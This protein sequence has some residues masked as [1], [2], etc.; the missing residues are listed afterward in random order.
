MTPRRYPN[1][2][3]GRPIV[4]VMKA[5]E[6]LANAGVPDGARALVALT[7]PGPVVVIE[8]APSTPKRVRRI[9]REGWRR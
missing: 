3:S 5:A 1:R 8:S 7:P 4:E 6:E 2:H 9:S